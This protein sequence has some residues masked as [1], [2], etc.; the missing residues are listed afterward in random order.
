MHEMPIYVTK[1]KEMQNDVN[2]NYVES[3]GC[4]GR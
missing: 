3:D 1:Q 4:L 2:R